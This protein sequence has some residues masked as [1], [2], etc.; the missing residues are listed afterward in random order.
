MR[1][2]VVAWGLVTTGLATGFVIDPRPAFT[3]D[4]LGV[5]RTTSS[6]PSSSAASSRTC[7]ARAG[8]SSTS[9]AASI[10]PFGAVPDDAAI[11]QL[12]RAGY[13]LQLDIDVRARLDH[14][15]GAILMS[16]RHVDGHA[17][18]V[19][20]RQRPFYDMATVRDARRPPS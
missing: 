4:T 7:G 5:G 1:R 11:R 16:R 20:R 14:R 18:E 10:Y 2:S 6:P 3:S 12:A 8:H 15:D 17:F 19:P 9:I 13:K